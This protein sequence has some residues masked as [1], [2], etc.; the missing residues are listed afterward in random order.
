MFKF[1]HAALPQLALRKALVVVDFQQDF[2]QPGGALET[3]E[4]EG[5]V[6]RT[7]KLA[8][9]FRSSGDIVWAKSQQVEGRTANDAKIVVSDTLTSPHTTTREGGRVACEDSQSINQDAEAFLGHGHTGDNQSSF[10]DGF[11]AAVL[12]AMEKKDIV[13]DKL[14]YSAFED[15]TLLR[16]LRAK[17]VTELY[18]CGSLANVG[19]HATA[20]D[21]AGHGMAIT[22]V[23]DCCGYRSEQRKSRAMKS[24]M[25]LT[26]C[27]IMSAQEV[28]KSI[29]SP[30]SNAATAAQKAI[31]PCSADISHPM[32]R[33]S[34]NHDVSP[35]T[36]TAGAGAEAEAHQPNA[37][38]APRNRMPSKTGELNGKKQ[39]QEI[40]TVNEEG[41]LGRHKYPGGSAEQRD[42]NRSRKKEELSSA[43]ANTAMLSQDSHESHSHSGDEEGPIL[44]G[45]C[46]G[47]TDVIENVLPAPL[48]D[49]VFDKLREEIQWQ[50]MSHQGGEVPRLVAVQGEVAED[51]SIPIYRH[52]SDESPPLLPFSPTVQAIR[53]A[54]EKHLGHSLNH[55]LIQ[56]YR[57]GH[58]YIS[59]H[60]DKTL[61]IAHN[62][63]IA[64]VSLGAQRTMVLRTKRSDKDKSGAASTAEENKRRVQRA[65]LP[66]NSLCRMG[67]QTNMKWLHSIRQ[68]KRADREKSATE[69]AYNSGRISL[70]FRRIG[71]F[72]S[73]EQ[74]KIWG[75]GATSKTSKD[76][77]DVINGQSEEGIS[78]LRAFG[79]ENHSSTFDWDLHYGKGFDVLHL[80]ASPRLFTSTD[81]VINLRISLMLAEYGINYAKGSI[82][83]TKDQTTRGGQ[84]LGAVET[85]PIKY[86]DNGDDK[87]E[88]HG[89]IAIMLYLHACHQKKKSAVTASDQAKQFTFFQKALC[90]LPAWRR[91]CE[92]DQTQNR[93]KDARAML[94]EYDIL[95]GTLAPETPFIGG[96]R[97]NLADFAFWP[98]LHEVVQ[99][100][101][102]EVIDYSASLR[103]YYERMKV[104]ESTRKVLKVDDASQ[105]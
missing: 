97:P 23:E 96:D 64:N 42:A 89:D 77:K 51:G 18:I 57:D 59:E 24:L 46:E 67:L 75:Q 94:S 93:V 7:L 45:L 98:T 99:S 10:Q 20:I 66:H 68:D 60:S 22:I 73:R 48:A 81:P 4:P 63:Y 71:T 29:Q 54:T 70:T 25:E 12:E 36:S 47:D 90:L 78:M 40:R 74:T 39:F 52:P 1:D 84:S 72:L 34:L 104:R 32:S 30:T 56:F 82:G 11:P 58:D 27:D 79:T 26:G 49:G 44:K 33:M 86:I 37:A 6:D 95:M 105:H 80:R 102:G 2:I 21:A 55:V 14:Q 88:V 103:A 9:A 38:I 50:R 8:A 91:A 15:T 16:A 101:G 65:P 83:P 28:L 85:P 19:V 3:T 35:P 43:P 61:D 87:A 100:C 5:Y 53:S 92:D 69:L 31:P 13:L 76:A 41:L 62:S 17:M